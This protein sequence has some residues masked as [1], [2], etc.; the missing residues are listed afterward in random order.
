MRKFAV[1]FLL[2]QFLIA[3][4]ISQNT[5]CWV[6]E[7]SNSTNALFKVGTEITITNDSI[8]FSNQSI[9]DR[10]P[11]ITNRSR[12]AI[13]AGYTRWLFSIESSSEKITLTELYIQSPLIIKLKRTDNLKI[14]K[15]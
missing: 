14:K 9:S 6:I 1:L 5:S 8:I 13:D 12:I 11:I 15:S 3:C 2:I 7:N 10:F 4:S